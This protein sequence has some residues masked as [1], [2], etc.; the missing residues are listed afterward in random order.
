MHGYSTMSKIVNKPHL[1]NALRKLKK[2]P[3]DFRETYNTATALQEMLEFLAV[4]SGLKPVL[5]IGRGF[6]DARWISG[7]N[8]VAEEMR[9]HVIQGPKLNAEPEI[10]DLPG[11]HSSTDQNRQSDNSLFYIC[12]SKSITKTVTKIFKSGNIT[13]EEESFLLGYPHCC[14][15]DHYYRMQMMKRGFQ[16]MLH[17][18][19]DG[20]EVELARLVNEDISMSPETDEEIKCI[21][22]GTRTIS[23]PYT[24]IV[25]CRACEENQNSPARIISRMLRHLAETVDLKFASEIEVNQRSF[26]VSDSQ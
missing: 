25:M 12:K 17:R 2:V 18:L 7:V 5:L 26:H 22:E 21:T 16:L 24:S 4:I 9:L 13:I 15:K 23:A 1:R 8:C 20:D 11:W 3:Y 19:A 14:V 10:T 6:D